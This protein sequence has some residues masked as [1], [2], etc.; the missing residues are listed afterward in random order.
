MEIRYIQG[1]VGTLKLGKIWFL[2]IL[3][4]NVLS[5][6][7][8]FLS[9]LIINSMVDKWWLSHSMSSTY[10]SSQSTLR[11]SFLLLFVIH[12]LNF[13]RVAISFYKY[14]FSYTK[15]VI[16]GQQEILQA[17]SY[18]PLKYL[19]H[20]LRTSVLSSGKSH[21]S[22]S[23]SFPAAAAAAKSLQLY[24]TLCDPIDGSPPGSTI[25]GILQ[26]RT[27]KRVA[28]SFSNAWKWKVKVKPFSHVRLLATPWTAA[29]QVPPSM[30]FS[31][32][33]DWS[34]LPLPSLAPD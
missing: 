4:P 1:Q 6:Y 19:L 11:K 30:G 13:T 26:V 18:I 33:E 23:S 25:P 17:F 3:A 12:L 7:C 2:I 22:S 9:V 15:Y 16:F 27:L 24:P 34:G 28:I 10:T 21:F 29:Y 20:V 5:T 32:Q 14:L 31:R 8:C